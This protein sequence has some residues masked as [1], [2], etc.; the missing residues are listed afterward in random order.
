MTTSGETPHDPY[1]PQPPYGQQPPPSG[2]LPVVTTGEE[3]NWAMA[4]HVGS[5]LAAW[6]ALGLLAPLV[7]LLTKGGGSRY[8]RRHAL[9]SL[10]FQVNALIYTVVFVWLSF[11]LIGIPLLVA[12]AVF[13]AICV[14]LATVRASSGEEFRYPLTVRLVS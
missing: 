3:R 7:V 12:Y 9:E 11:L 4:A 10:N 8:I 1:G 13:Y 14:I 2:G 6:F 5:F